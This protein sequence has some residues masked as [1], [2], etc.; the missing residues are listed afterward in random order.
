VRLTDSCR[1]RS[2]QWWTLG[3]SLIGS[4]GQMSSKEKQPRFKIREIHIDL[5]TFTSFQVETK[6]KNLFG[7]I[8]CISIQ[9]YEWLKWQKHLIAGKEQINAA[10]CIIVALVRA[11]ANPDISVSKLHWQLLNKKVTFTT[12]Q[13]NLIL[14]QNER[15]QTRNDR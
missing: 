4:Y 9:N 3:G 11:A 13:N 7:N 15:K 12:I 2:L 6:S 14:I 1:L 8:W 10:L 5:S